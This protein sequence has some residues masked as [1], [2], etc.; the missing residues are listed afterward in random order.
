MGDNIYLGD[1]NGVRTP[2]QWTSDRNA[3]FSRP[4]RRGCTRRSIMDPVYGYQ[5][6]QRRGAGALAVVAAELDEAHHRP[7]ARSHQHVRPRHAS[8][9]SRRRTARC[10]PTCASTRARRSSASRTCR[11]TRSRPSS[12]C[13]ASR[14][15]CRSRCSADTEFPRDRRAAL[16]PHPRAVRLLLV[17]AARERR[18]RR[19]S[20]AGA[21]VDA[22]AARRARSA[23]AAAGRVW[24]SAFDTATHE[25]LERDYLPV[26]LATR[27][28]F[29]AK[30]ASLRQVRIR[31]HVAVVGGPEP[32]F[33]TLLDV[34]FDDGARRL[35]AADGVP[36][37]ARRPRT[38]CASRPTR[39]RP[40]QR[41]AHGRACT[42]GSTGASPS[43]CS[44]RRPATARSPAAQDDSVGE[45]G[46]DRLRGDPGADAT[47]TVERS[48]PSRAT[49]RSSVGDRLILKL[50]RRV[51][52]GP[53]PELEISCHLT[54]RVRL[55]TRAA[56]GRRA[57][58]RQAPTASRALA[59]LHGLVPALGHRLGPGARRAWTATSKRVRRAAAAPP[60]LEHDRVV[61]RQRWRRSE[62]AQRIC[63][64]RWRPLQA[65]RRSRA[66][67]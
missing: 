35:S 49:R 46:D 43:C 45:H 28:W 22:Q 1:R 11:G 57:R 59:V 53:N 48:A 36:R 4:T 58:I 12:T 34:D 60:A 9:S 51:E 31:D 23:A 16:L 52:P 5:A 18:R 47:L 8:A 54:E 15:A 14:A 67:P 56:A 37:P 62:R 42:S 33:L 65:S 64:T 50:I 63:T 30:A 61:C 6:R 26:H 21:A 41:R 3:G 2:M 38:C 40:R 20:S 10:W 44:M 29:A 7:A 19:P 27:R 24:D 13:A 66:V 17:P 32:V 39:H 55:R 25:I